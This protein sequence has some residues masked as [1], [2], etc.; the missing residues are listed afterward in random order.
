LVGLGHSLLD[1][2]CLQANPRGFPPWSG[3]PHHEVRMSRPPQTCTPSRS[4]HVAGPCGPPL[5]DPVL[6]RLSADLRSCVHSRSGLLGLPFGRTLPPARSCSASAVS[7]RPDGFLRTRVAGLLR[8]AASSRFNA[9]PPRR[10]E[11]RR[12]S[13]A[14]GFPALHTTLRRTLLD[15]GRVA[16]LRPLPS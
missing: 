13:G 8:P 11:T 10:P 7:H 16:S 9:F 12:S 4:L 14:F 5:V 1:L 2:A 3:H 15:V 6:L